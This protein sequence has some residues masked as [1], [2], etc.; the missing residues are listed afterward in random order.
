VG[1]PR[2]GQG[3]Q[4]AGGESGRLKQPSLF[5]PRALTLVIIIIK[6]LNPYCFLIGSAVEVYFSVDKISN[7][8]LSLNLFEAN[9]YFYNSSLLGLFFCFKLTL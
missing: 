3:L 5:L 1:K 7:Y 2:D 9:I 6:H 8:L 4:A